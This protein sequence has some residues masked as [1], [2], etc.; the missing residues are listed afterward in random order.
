MNRS[1]EDFEALYRE[2]PLAANYP[3]IEADA[4]SHFQASQSD[5][6]A[7]KLRE[8]Q[9]L[10]RDLG[11]VI[12]LRPGARILVIGTGPQPIVV[13]ELARHGFQADGVEPVPAFV[14]AANELLAGAGTVRVG[15]AEATGAADASY[16]VVL[17]ESVLEHVDSP[18][19]SL[20]EAYRILRP[21][22]LL[23][24]TTTNRWR[25]SWRGENGEYNVPFFNYLPRLVQEMYVTQHLLYSPNLANYSL[26]P[27]VH[28]FTYAK[29]CELGRL[30]GFAQFFSKLDVLPVDTR[31]GLRRR[32]V[33]W[34]K[35]NPW[36]RALVLMQFGFT[37][38]MV[39][40]PQG[41]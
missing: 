37:I 12:D 30:A 7:T 24:V 29:L 40:R 9:T 21:G 5:V 8:V 31:R 28:W 18:L 20:Q 17:L 11:R 1:R 23:Y 27:A 35:Y 33:M 10:V 6:E 14:D 34:A 26:R 39:K 15:T 38:F 25:F 3:D 16:D 36:L 4:V 2:R 19:A 32:L 13:R 41:S 22:G